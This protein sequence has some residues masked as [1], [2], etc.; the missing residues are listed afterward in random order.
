MRL[1][2][3]LLSFTGLAFGGWYVWENVP[4]V[5]TFVQKKV[6]EVS[7]FIQEKVPQQNGFQTLEI[8]FPAV[9]IMRKNA[10][11]LLKSDEYSYQ[12]SKLLY[13]PYLLMNVKYSKDQCTTSEGVL[14]WG[15]NDGEMVID[16][17]S[18]EKTHGFEDC[19]L[20]NANKN[21]FRVISALV[22]CGGA[23]DRE[24]LY[25]RFKIDHDILDDWLDSCR[26]KKL[27]V[28]NGNQFRLHFQDPRLE[29]KP[30]THFDLTIVSQQARNA[31]KVK[32]RYTHSQIKKLTEIAFGNDFSIRKSEIIFLPVYSIAIQNP[33]GS[34][35]TVFFN[36]V[37][38]KRITGS[39]PEF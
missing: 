15:L 11:Q 6:P 2:L 1:I 13:Y 17:A 27:I 16:T 3:S 14:L 35:R 26:A 20:V 39:H 8:R 30:I 5:S 24:K 22:E 9:E 32:K 18:W 29:I 7:A 33:D 4:E 28:V 19:L 36:A 31:T 21:D 25:Q 10:E 23:I 34:L 37:N 38:G 12:E